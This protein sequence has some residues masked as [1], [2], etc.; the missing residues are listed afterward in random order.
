MPSPKCVPTKKSNESEVENM[1]IIRSDFHT[2]IPHSVAN[3]IKVSEKR[4]ESEFTVYSMDD[5][6]RF[7]LFED[8]AFIFLIKDQSNDIVVSSN[9]EFN[10]ILNSNNNDTFTVDFLID[11]T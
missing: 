8:G 3:R 11:H 6:N 2:T 9:K 5:F 1:A 7:I 4:V 10:I